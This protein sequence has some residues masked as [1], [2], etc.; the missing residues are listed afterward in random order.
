MRREKEPK[1]K[2]EKKMVCFFFVYGGVLSVWGRIRGAGFFGVS[3]GEL[4]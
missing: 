1:K 4:L 3:L 2:K